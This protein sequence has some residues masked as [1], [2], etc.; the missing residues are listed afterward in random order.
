ME[1]SIYMDLAKGKL[2]KQ[3]QPIYIPKR[4]SYIKSKVSARRKAQTKRGGHK[5]RTWRG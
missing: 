4:G 5:R 2:F 3:G 1:D